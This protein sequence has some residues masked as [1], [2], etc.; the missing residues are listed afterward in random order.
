M[1]EWSDN[2]AELLLAPLVPE[3]V[4]CESRRDLLA[5]TQVDVA[6]LFRAR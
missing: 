4:L 1:F 3:A 5:G 2:A 6:G